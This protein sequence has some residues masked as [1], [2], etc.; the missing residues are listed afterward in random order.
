MSTNNKIGDIQSGERAR[1]PTSRSAPEQERGVLAVLRALA[2]R[3]PLTR[4]EAEVLAELQ[5]NRLLELADVSEP[6]VPSELITELPRILVR[7]DI[8]LPVSGSAHW[9]SGRWLLSINAAEPW[10]RQRF[11]LAHEFKHVLDHSWRDVLYQDRPGE[12][13]DQQAEHA[14]DYF[15]ACLLMPKRFVKRLWG[16]RQ[17][18]LS[19]LSEHFGV[20]P[21]AM[22]V[23]L[24]ALGLRDSTERCQRGPDQG[25]IGR[26]T[27]RRYY[28]RTAQHY[29]GIA[30]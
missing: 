8:D 27:R 9:V 28:Q 12:T 30:A 6:P 10:Q 3:R 16:D 21:R 18:R 17:Q 4:P 26:P 1:L 14:A 7:A 29:E 15:A 24:R 2:P 5:A 19:V 25:P 23:R 13:A 20:S 11:S 22:Q